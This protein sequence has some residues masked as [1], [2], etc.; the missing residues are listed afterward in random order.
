M[1]LKPSLLDL[2]YIEYLLIPLIFVLIV[3]LLTLLDPQSLPPEIYPCI[4]VAP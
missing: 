3:G 1:S 4:E 2:P